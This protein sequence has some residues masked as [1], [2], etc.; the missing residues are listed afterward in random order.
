MKYLIDYEYGIAELY[1]PCTDWEYR[2]YTLAEQ[3]FGIRK[4][5]WDVELIR[6]EDIRP[7]DLLEDEYERLEHDGDVIVWNEDG[8]KIKTEWD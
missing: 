6:S 7:D 8:I 4:N 2:F 3:C 1:T 5:I